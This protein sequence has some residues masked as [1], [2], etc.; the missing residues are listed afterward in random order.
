MKVRHEPRVGVALG[1]GAAR[2]LA[3][4][5]VLSVL[6]TERIPIHALT[7][8]SIGAVVAAAYASG[9]PIDS[10]IEIGRQTRWRDLG[11]F[12]LSSRGFQSSE[13]MEAWLERLLPVR[14][15]EELEIP[16][17]VVATDLVTGRAVI[18]SSGD[19][20]RAVRASC[21]IPGLYVPVEM[22]G[23][24]LADGYLTCNLPAAPLR[25]MG[26][27]VVV[28]SAIGLEVSDDVK[29]NNAYQILLRAF[30]IMSNAAQ[31]SHGDGA[32]VVIEADVKSHTWSDLGAIDALVEAGAAAARDKRG[33]IRDA[34][35][36]PLVT[37]VKRQLKRLL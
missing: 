22:N 4:L 15:F 21:A 11:R 31:R 16:L 30:S 36:P 8:V 33:E 27:D 2:G 7:G 12:S 34:I 29:L 23:A 25:D 6:E 24:V 10:L 35:D 9:L 32:D 3:H 14:T 18:L 5:G 28:A 37:R 17:R 1:G 26:A 20:L 13:R 19:L